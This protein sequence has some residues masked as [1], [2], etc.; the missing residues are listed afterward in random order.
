MREV[1]HFVFTDD[2]EFVANLVEFGDDFFHDI[3]FFAEGHESGLKAIDHDAFDFVW[4]EMEDGAGEFVLVGN[5]R[6]GDESIIG[7]ERDAK[8]E[9]HIELEWVIFDGLDGAGLNVAL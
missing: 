7:I 2:P 1:V 4:L 9:I 3:A 6:V 5:S 8:P